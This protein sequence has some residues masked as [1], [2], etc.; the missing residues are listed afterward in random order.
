M[1]LAC[2]ITLELT[3]VWGDERFCCSKNGQR[4]KRQVQR[5]VRCLVGNS[6]DLLPIALRRRNGQFAFLPHRFSPRNSW[7]VVSDSGSDLPT[8]NWRP[9][10]P[11]FSAGLKI[12]S[13]MTCSN[14]N[15]RSAY[16]SS[17]NRDGDARCSSELPN[18]HCCTP[19]AD[20]KN[21]GSATLGAQT[22]RK[23]IPAYSC[24][25][26]SIRRAHLALALNNCRKI[27]H[28]QTIRN[29]LACCPCAAEISAAFRGRH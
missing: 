13:W 9:F 20:D 28:E 23:T 6:T 16:P 29:L 11:S 18:Q 21:F 15:G 10:S 27:C 24:D 19:P 26:S 17:C 25:P 3:C 2:P 12:S 8:S 22:C 5:L 1:L 4:V 7:P 14:P